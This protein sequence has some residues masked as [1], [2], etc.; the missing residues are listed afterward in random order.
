MDPASVARLLLQTSQLA[1]QSGTALY[2]FTRDAQNVNGSVAELAIELNSL[3]DACNTVRE[4]L[5]SFA[6]QYNCYDGDDDVHTSLW[7]SQDRCNSL[8]PFAEQILCNT[9]RSWIL[10]E[11][12]SEM[13]ISMLKEEKRKKPEPD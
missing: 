10:T 4:Q 7:A 3:A 5:R 11:R 2:H 12:T 1:L 8:D 6:S 13:Y 9:A